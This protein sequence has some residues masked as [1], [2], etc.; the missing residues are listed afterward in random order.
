MIISSSVPRPIYIGLAPFL[1]Y[2]LRNDRGSLLANEV[3]VDPLVVL[4]AELAPE[5]GGQE[6][7]YHSGDGGN[8][9]GGCP[10][11]HVDLREPVGELE[12]IESVV[13]VAEIDP[14]GGKEH[15]QHEHPQCHRD[16]VESAVVTSHASGYPS[17]KEERDEDHAGSDRK[18]DCLEL[19]DIAV[20]VDHVELKWQFAGS[21]RRQTSHEQEHPNSSEQAADGGRG[22]YPPKPRTGGATRNSLDNRR[23]S[24]ASYECLLRY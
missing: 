21:R 19:A 15:H 6:A 20:L 8:D 18:A 2:E 3:G 24:P 23:V 14:E 17:S 9:A 22:V 16:P 11:I 5:G 13:L 10:L 12:V 4:L 7:Q 1:A